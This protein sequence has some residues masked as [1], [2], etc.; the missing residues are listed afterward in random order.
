MHITQFRW[1][2]RGERRFSAEGWNSLVRFCAP[3]SKDRLRLSE[4]RGALGRA[5]VLPGV[6][7]G[8]FPGAIAY[9]SAR[10]SAHRRRFRAAM[11]AAASPVQ[12]DWCFR[13]C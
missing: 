1:K 10:G 9:E 12:R 2:F 11:I 5:P 4:G 8:R 7:P 3:A 13:G 6:L